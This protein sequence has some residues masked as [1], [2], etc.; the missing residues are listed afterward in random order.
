MQAVV[1]VGGKGTRLRQLT[2]NTPKPM[3]QIAGTPFV[4]LLCRH[5]ELAGFSKILLLAGF[6]GHIVSSYFAKLPKFGADISVLVEPE[7]VGT[8]GAIR[9]A[10]EHLEETFVLLNGDTWFDIPLRELITP[11]KVRH[12]NCILNIAL[13]PAT[14]E[15]RF[16]SAL[17]EKGLVTKFGADAESLHEGTLINCGIYYIKRKLLGHI[18]KGFVSLENDIIPQLAK[19]K[20]VSGDIFDAPFIDIGIPSEFDRSQYVIPTL[21]RKPSIFLQNN[22]SPDQTEFS[23]L[24]NTEKPAYAPKNLVN[25]ATLL[26]IRVFRVEAINNKPKVSTFPFEYFNERSA[27]EQNHFSGNA[28]AEL[29]NYIEPGTF[30]GSDIEMYNWLEANHFCNRYCPSLSFSTF[31]TP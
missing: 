12:P 8:G 25:M 31:S 15:E 21:M 18:P 26:G 24:E 1:L 27:S 29:K 17:E 11:H 22:P 20:L 30:F 28:L 9:E 5:L 19:Q 23:G 10:A 13:K 3:L 14:S 16:G 7:P 2:K 6:E 4:H